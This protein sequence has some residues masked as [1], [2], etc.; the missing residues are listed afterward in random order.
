MLFRLRAHRREIAT[1]RRCR[2]TDEANRGVTRNPRRCGVSMRIR[3]VLIV[4]VLRPK[5]KI[6]TGFC[7]PS[8][9]QASVAGVAGSREIETQLAQRYA[10]RV[11][12]TR[13]ANRFVMAE[14]RSRARASPIRLKVPAT[15][16][17]HFQTAEK[18][19]D[20]E[21]RPQFG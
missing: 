14:R 10:V 20:R 1:R 15:I 21:T 17:V 7:L 18:V 16:P 8:F 9:L 11:G 12:T 5:A 3:F 6:S 2:R 4:L 13:R 19:D